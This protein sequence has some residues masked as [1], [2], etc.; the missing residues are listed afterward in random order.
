MIQF[1]DKYNDSFFFF[2]K[3]KYLMPIDI[4]NVNTKFID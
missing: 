2:W 4:L 3:K 1:I